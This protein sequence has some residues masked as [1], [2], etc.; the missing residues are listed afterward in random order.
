MYTGDRVTAPL[1]HSI[2]R[3]SGIVRSDAKRTR[4][5]IQ[6]IRRRLSPQAGRSCPK[7]K[8]YCSVARPV[9]VQ[10]VD[11]TGGEGVPGANCTDDPI[12][13]DGLRRVNLADMLLYPDNAFGG[14]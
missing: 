10:A 12:R 8:I 11:H 4:Q 9:F 1:G 5:T 13:G 7:S 14:M 3:A 6:P 2:V